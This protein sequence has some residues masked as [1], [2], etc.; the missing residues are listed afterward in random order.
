MSGIKLV[1]PTYEIVSINRKTAAATLKD[2]R[3]GDHIRF[4][5]QMKSVGG[6]SGGG[7]Y[8]STYTALNLTQRSAVIKSQTQMSGFFGFGGDS[9]HDQWA[10]FTIREV[11]EDA[12][13]R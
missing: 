11:R 9:M 4:S 6:A 10:T 3:I 5:T 8:A 7:V 12:D 1:S 13:E 2:W